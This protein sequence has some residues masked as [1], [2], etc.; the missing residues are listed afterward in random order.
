VI[1]QGPL[2]DNEAMIGFGAEGY[3]AHANEL[4]LVNNTLFD[5]LPGGGEFVRARPD[6]A[7]RL[8]ALNN[9]LIG[10]G[11]F[12]AE[13]GGGSGN[14]RLLASDVVDASAYAMQLR[15]NAYAS[16]RAVDAGESNGISLRQPCEYRHPR[17]SVPL[18]VAPLHPGACQTQI[19]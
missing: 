10:A 18:T 6:D 2:T 5:E 9:V 13:I 8:V 17:K 4:Y 11:R 14:V 15:A 16:V 7:L 1:A 3:G 12:V 19:R